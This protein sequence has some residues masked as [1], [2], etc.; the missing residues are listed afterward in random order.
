MPPGERPSN[1]PDMLSEKLIGAIEADGGRY[2]WSRASHC[3]CLSVN[4]DTDQADPNCVL[5]KGIGTLF[6]GPVDYAPADSVGDL[7]DVQEAILAV[8]GAAV[9]RG[10][11]GRAARGFTHRE[12]M[13]DVIGHWRWGEA[14]ITVRPENRLG[15]LDRLVSLDAVICHSEVVDLVAG[16]ATVPLRYKA[17]AVNMLRSLTTVFAEDVEFFLDAGTVNWHSAFI[18]D[19]DV[20][21]V[22]HYLMHPTW[23]VVDMPHSI[24]EIARRHPVPRTGPNTPF[25]QP[26][27][28]PIA[29]HIQLEHIPPKE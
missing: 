10:V 29:A 2:A 3:P 17:V 22:V 13:F 25:G 7:D 27:E 18:P 15:Y 11:A 26:T 12:T 5:C 8:D 24:R 23:R 28:L 6:F 1:Y 14:L 4:V 20:R 16:A 21:V 9:I 19:E